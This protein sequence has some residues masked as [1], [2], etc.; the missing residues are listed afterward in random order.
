V[1]DSL[2][3]KDLFSKSSKTVKNEDSEVQAN[4]SVI[5]EKI[6][7]S[8]II[9]D[10][11]RWKKGSPNLR[12]KWGYSENTEL[13][14]IEERLRHEGMKIEEY[15]VVNRLQQKSMKKEAAN[16]KFQFTFRD[17]EQLGT[18][19]VSVSV[20]ESGTSTDPRPEKD[21]TGLTYGSSSE[22]FSIKTIPIPIPK[23]KPEPQANQHKIYSDEMNS[24]D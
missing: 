19:S 10:P 20:S 6:S 11:N 5:L 21:D 2:D 3:V 7:P 24:F 16:E 12:S 18:V 17:Q 23:P 13:I 9:P 4:R 1:N 22:D 14:K 15:M 8:M